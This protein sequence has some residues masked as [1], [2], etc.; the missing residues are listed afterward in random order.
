MASLSLFF[1]RPPE[2]II[3]RN[4]V[5]PGADVLR[6]GLPCGLC[7]FIVEMKSSVYMLELVGLTGWLSTTQ[8][9]V[10]W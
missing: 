6:V 1:C 10:P 8:L 7:F 2:D 9:Y 4:E 5:I 3:E